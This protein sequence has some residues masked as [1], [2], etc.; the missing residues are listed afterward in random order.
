MMCQPKQSSSHLF[1]RIEHL[2]TPG[3]LDARSAGDRGTSEGGRRRPAQPRGAVGGYNLTGRQD[4]ADGLRRHGGVRAGPHPPA[5]KLRAGCRQDAGRAL[6]A[7]AE[8]DAGAD[9]PGSPT[10]GRGHLSPGRREAIL[11]SDVFGLESLV[12]F[13]DQD[14]AAGAT[15]ASTAEASEIGPPRCGLLHRRSRPG[16]KGAAL[17]GRPSSC[18]QSRA[19]HGHQSLSGAEPAWRAS[20]VRHL[21]S[22]PLRAENPTESCPQGLG[23]SQFDRRAGIGI[24]VPLK[25]V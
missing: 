21:E 22:D 6:R 15:P 18:G 7:P 23:I 12:D 10:C 3:A 4:G 9:R 24:I 2:V 14:A 5:N 25:R 13:L 19:A 16:P 8:A 1:A 11:A 17:A 20:L